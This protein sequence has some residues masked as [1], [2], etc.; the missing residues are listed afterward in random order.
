MALL[1][2][3][4]GGGDLIRAGLVGRVWK[5]CRELTMK[6]VKG[7]ISNTYTE[8]ALNRLRRRITPNRRCSR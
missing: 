6:G 2:V 1:V 7:R 4:H 3:V 8:C 5:A